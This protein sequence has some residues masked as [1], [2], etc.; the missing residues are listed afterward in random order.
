M[1]KTAIVVPCFNEE[2]RLNTEEFVKAIDDDDSL[3]FI[4]V[5]DGSDDGTGGM[6]EKMSADRPGRMFAV[7]LDTNSGKAEATRRGFNMA[8]ENGYELIGYLDADLATPICA[9]RDFA[10]IMER[11]NVLMTMGSR[12]RLLGR[13][14]KR[15][16]A[17]HYLGRL[18]ATFASVTLNLP[19]YDTQCGAKLFR[20]SEPVRKIFATPFGARWVFDVE[21]IARL[22]LAI[23]PGDRNDIENFIIEHPLDQWKDVAGSKIKFRDFV[24]G[25]MELAFIMLRYSRKLY[26]MKRDSS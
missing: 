21:I 2:K 6:I 10:A 24:I 22:A 15:S 26:S 4:F 12:V 23:R 25:A 5:N 11:N 14:V 8:F 3:H 7:S 19:V 16:S 20:N 18:F 9:I 17:R 13:D 1:S